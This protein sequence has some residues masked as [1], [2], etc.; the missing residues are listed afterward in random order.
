MTVRVLDDATYEESIVLDDPTRHERLVL[1]AP[2]HATL[3]LSGQARRCVTINGV[4]QV[5]LHGFRFRGPN[6]S[7]FS[8]FV[9]L[10]SDC[11]GVRLEELDMQAPGVVHGISV[12]NVT[13]TSP[14]QPVII[15]RSRFEVGA[16]GI[17][18]S[19]TPIAMARG[20]LIRENRLRGCAQG[21]FIEKAVADVQVAGNIIWG[22][23]NAGIQIED[24]DS[25]SHGILVAN[26]S[27]FECQSAFR[28]WDKEPQQMVESGQ[29][30]FSSN[31]LFGNEVGDMLYILQAGGQKK[32]S[33]DLAR[34]IGELWRFDSNWRDLKGF[35][36]AAAVPL[37]PKDHQIE[38]LAW[39]SR[40]TQHP[41]FMRP[42]ADS[43]LATAGAGVEDPS[44]PPYVGAV[45]PPGVSLWDWDKTWQSR[46]QSQS[47]DSEQKP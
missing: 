33:G 21:V 41:D 7:Q 44:L 14:Q 17:W 6:A 15:S 29:V 3:L 18:I 16:R 32:S 4:P 13:I 45:P 35:E 27:L 2:Q 38:R 46:R 24:L 42:P 22:S 43:P 9:M 26:N 19:G 39:L 28:V 30:E 8:I 10:S 1:E 23:S 40:E 20:I 12:S 5:R 47:E 37:A 11:T 34:S 36:S 25:A 31:L